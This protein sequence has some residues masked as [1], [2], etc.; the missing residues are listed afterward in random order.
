MSEQWIS[1]ATMFAL[2]V[3]PVAVLIGS[4][5]L[6]RRVYHRRDRRNPLTKNLLRPPGY[7]LSEQIDDV[8]IDMMALVA[9]VGPAP[10]LVWFLYTRSNRSVFI[11]VFTVL[12]GVGVLA[13]A[14]YRMVG[15]VKR[16]RKIRLGWE[17]EMAAGQELSLLMHDRFHVFHDVPGDGAFNVD[18]V[19]VGA[20]GVFCIE[21]KGRA[22]PVH[23]DGEGH[24]VRYDGKQ[25]QFPG[26]TETA[27]LE[28]AR[29]NADWLRKWLS[30]AVGT[31]IEVK[32]VLILPGWFIERS[33]PAGVP[34][35]NGVNCRNFFMKQS[36]AP[37]SEQLVKQIVHQLDARCRDVEPTT[38]R[39]LKD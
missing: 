17:A 35:M 29:R 7:T 32:P 22:K 3:L 1:V 36:A 15:N 31:P 4:V 21:T 38:N 9:A 14:V 13:Y 10:L 20:Q 27:P 37:I 2:Y 24:K 33:S 30:S 12:L 8:R 23:A 39:P 18:H 16:A 26:W 34:V 6:A 11:A 28:Q 5:A 19:V 25:L